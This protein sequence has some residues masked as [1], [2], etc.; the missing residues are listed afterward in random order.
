MSTLYGHVTRHIPDTV[1]CIA[2]SNTFLPP[3]TISFMTT[4]ATPP[5]PPKP[6]SKVLMKATADSRKWQ[7]SNADQ[8]PVKQSCRGMKPNN[9]NH[10]DNN[11]DNLNPE[12]TDMADVEDHVTKARGRGGKKATGAQRKRGPAAA[13]Y[14][15]HMINGHHAINCVLSP[16]HF[17]PT[18]LP[19]QEDHPGPQS[20]RRG[21]Q[22]PTQV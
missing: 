2:T 1:V 10:N 20:R 21:S 11:N 7:A 8:Q 14:V 16:P 4:T 5:M 6:Q 22:N 12:D 19:P 15:T 9:N 3:T 17:R 13:K 18:D